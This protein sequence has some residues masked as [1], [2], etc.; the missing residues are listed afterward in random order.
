M[1][2]T[3]LPGNDVAADRPEAPEAVPARPGSIFQGDLPLAQ[4]LDR[5]RMELLDLSARNRLL[6]LPRGAGRSR[7]IE[8][9]DEVSTEIFRLLVGE[10][11]RFTF[12]PGREAVPVD[13]GQGDQ[14][15][16]DDTSGDDT[17]GDDMPGEGTPGEGTPG[18]GTQPALAQPDDEPLDARGIA[19]RHADTR[20]Q[21][22]LSSEGLQRR[23]LDLYLDARTLE[24]EQGVNIL[25]LALGALSWV[26]PNSRDTPRRAPL[27]LVPVQL[28][29]ASAADRFRLL[30][31]PEDIATNLSLEAFLDRQHAIRLPAL[32]GGEDP[33]IA[34]YMAAVAEA[35]AAK[36]AAGWSVDPDAITLGFFSFSKF[37]MYRDLDPEIWPADSRLTDRP[38]IRGLLEDGFGAADEG[39]DDDVPVDPLIPPADFLHIVDCDSSQ[40]L[41]V[42]EV[43]RGRDLV[44][45]GPPGTGKSQTIANV[46]ASAIFDGKTVLFVAEKMAALEVVKRRLDQAG[47]GDICLELHSNKASKRQVLDELK[48]TWDLGSPRIGDDAALIDR[49]TE[50]RDTLNA[51]AERLHR[52]LPPT[53]LTPYRVI[54]ELVRLRASGIGAVDFDLDGLAPDWTAADRETRMAMLRDLGDRL[55]ALGPP[56]DHPW[57]GIGLDMVTPMDVER[58]IAEIT[59]LRAGFAAQRDEA[60]ELAARLETDPPASLD[61]A[62][63][64][65]ARAGRLAA[66]PD[67]EPA[68]MLRP[69]WSQQARAI[70]V[71]VETG[72][73]H[74]VQAQAVRP[75]VTTEALT[76]PLADLRAA[77]D[78][79]QA[80]PAGFGPAARARMRRV[81]GG[82]SALIQAAERLAGHLGVTAPQSLTGM[83]ALRRQGEAVADAPDVPAAV[84]GAVAWDDRTADLTDL[85]EA[86]RGYHDARAASASLF[87]D[88]AWGTDLAPA[89]Q[90]LADG[91]T[92]M[93]K[94]FS[95]DW[96]RANRLVTS[97]LTGPRP[98]ALPDLLAALDQVIAGRAAAARAVAGDDLGRAAFGPLWRCER[99]DPAPLEAVLAWARGPASAPE[100]RRITAACADRV[101]AG[102]LA[103]RLALAVAALRLD[104]AGLHDDLGAAVEAVT[105]TDLGAERVVLVQLGPRLSPLLAAD[106]VAEAALRAAPDGNDAR[107][108]ALTALIDLR[109]LED[110]LAAGSVLGRDAFG[111]LWPGD[112]DGGAQPPAPDWTLVDWRQ[113][114]R[115]VDWMADNPDLRDLAARTP[116][117]IGLHRRVA[118]LVDAGPGLV[119]ETVGLWARLAFDPRPVFGDA[120]IPDLPL[121]VLIAHADGWI[122][123][124]EGLSAWTAL[125]AAIARA[126]AA[127]LDP[128]VDRL[129][130]G[131]LDRAGVIAAFEMAVH[132]AVLAVMLAADPALGRFDGTEHDGRVERF[133]ALDTARIELA[134][135]EVRAEHA[136]RR[137]RTTG[138]GAGPLGVLRGEISKKRRHLPIR[139]LMSAA[140]PAVQALKP[141][142]MMSPLSVAQFLEPGRVTFDLL[143]IDEASQ[144]QP[145]DALGAI[146]RCRQIVVVGDER[147]LPPTRF[148]ARMTADGVADDEDDETTRV[149]D[150]ESILGLCAARGLPQR[151]LRWHYRSRHQSLIAVSNREFYQDRLYVVP[152]PYTADA[153]VGL[154]FTY[155]ADGVF[156]RGGSGTNPVEAR[157]VARAVIDHALT[158]PGQSLGVATFSVRQRRAIL[159]EL[160]A[161]RRLHPEAE[162]FFQA[163][164]AEP[165]FVKNLENVQGDERDQ[166]FISVGY[167]RNAQGHMA[168]NFGPLGAEGGERRLNVLISRAKRRC[169][170]FASITDEDI[171]L[172]RARGR[173]VV[174]FK[175][176]MNYARTG[177]L[178]FARQT[179][180]APDSAFEAEVARALRA[181]GHTVH[182]QVGLAGFFIDLAVVDPE[183]PGRYL[184]GIECDG[185][186]YHGAR[187]ARD[188][189]RLRQ[190]VLED[191]GWIIHRIWSTDWFNRPDTQLAAVE[192]AIR[193]AHDMLEQR[194]TGGT[195]SAGRAV[196]VDIVTIEGEVVDQIGLELM[197]GPAVAGAEDDGA[198]PDD[199]AVVP[200]VEASPAVPDDLAASD[201]PSAPPARLADLVVAV[202]TVEG[203]VHVDEV[204]LRL[205]EAWGLGRSGA[206][207]QAAVRTAARLAVRRGEIIDTGGFLG[208]PGMPLRLRDRSTVGS[209]SLR[210]P[211]MLPPA[212]IAHGILRVITD[213]PGAAPAELP[214]ELGRML[215]FKAV[216]AGLRALIDA[217]TARL[218]TAGVLITRDGQVTLAPPAIHDDVQ[219]LAGPSA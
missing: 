162:G 175:L 112:G 46:V 123:A 148:F 82:L 11:R 84:L 217:E 91:G 152:S 60:A 199:A 47:V 54:G 9:T 64:L 65:L 213:N 120:A 63:F 68:A 181:H 211:D 204:T 58:R 141:V 43:R 118:A 110:S 187:S 81:A 89:R 201:L 174:A 146:A 3:M 197:A 128:L 41:A 102:E 214:R 51:H 203:P 205:R 163:H 106:A 70:R 103:R 191:H 158:C 153:G 108:A 44:I 38:L 26:D 69:V 18:E 138:A 35:V 155:V 149:A 202:V 98:E 101:L 97:V 90:A 160:E 219:D 39:Y 80:L 124:P 105:G 125:V 115:A 59:R 86:V 159:D 12:L 55:A 216:S 157:A 53:G 49:L 161:L 198:A 212:E 23:L 176:F 139:Q 196:P 94:A 178:G 57:R 7:N 109:D 30:A 66:A 177:S 20:L 29:R 27:I 45:Q 182:E 72:A 150:I 8:V 78:R 134:R 145:V 185:A 137:P 56:G 194:L 136:R 99:S 180:R 6:N 215:G 79:L 95:G 130:D 88:I 119:D 117:R 183:R 5:A 154:G 62:G 4:K 36:S 206:R 179:G 151:M 31:R 165:F 116:D 113:L 37:L 144:I 22:R 85:V 75:V 208:I 61:A 135:A 73:R 16:G 15:S 129:E 166:I 143:V 121:D 140:G 190:A 92:G 52:P 200:Y 147:Q 218:V 169:M 93:F 133:A 1:A 193:R 71:L 132:E 142:F 114:A 74:L 13:G 122:G 126:R 76:M 171:D 167:A 156:E 32:E 168:M 67:I 164:E 127:G 131:R 192:Q 14:A 100:T 172:E 170:V 28:E 184:L 2:E 189:D 48:R 210:K 87:G 33:D 111:R 17:S 25:Y 195:A 10:G 186:A 96:R 207:I 104:L 40:T 107:V 34:G 50:A 77:R 209:S 83:E 42:H 188:R 24:E 173:G 19:A 21:T